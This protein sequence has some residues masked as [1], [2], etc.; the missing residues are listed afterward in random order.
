MKRTFTLLTALLFTTL[1]FAQPVLA[2]DP[3]ALNGPAL[4]EPVDLT[5]SGDGSGRLFV[6]EKRGSVRIIENNIV[7]DDYFLDIHTQVMNSGERGLLGMAFHPQYPDSPY[8]YVNYVV[9]STII[10]RISRFTLSSDPNDI[11]EDSEVIYFEQ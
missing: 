5:G 8:I 2:F 9:V 1:S 3:V 11:D 7:L 4:L 10:N 6:V